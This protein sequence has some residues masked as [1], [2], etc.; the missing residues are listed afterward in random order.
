MSKARYLEYVPTN[1]WES[2]EW[3]EHQWPTYMAGRSAYYHA[4]AEANNYTLLGEPQITEDDTFPSPS[5]NWSTICFQ[6]EM[7][8]GPRP[9]GGQVLVADEG[10]RPEDIV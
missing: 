3:R 8:R 5:D 7:E 1:L 4:V 10:A 2:D 6:W 9:P